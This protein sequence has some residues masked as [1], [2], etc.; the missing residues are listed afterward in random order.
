MPLC[1]HSLAVDLNRPRGILGFRCK[2][3]V[4]WAVYWG[5]DA[6]MIPNQGP[7]PMCTF[8]ANT[9]QRFAVIVG[10]AAEGVPWAV[11]LDMMHDMASTDD[12]QRTEKRALEA[13]RRLDGT[14]AVP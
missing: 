8:H 4:K 6:K 12:H 10:G 2:R 11:Y 9:T 13:A 3:Q 7:F 14:A 1:V 5:P